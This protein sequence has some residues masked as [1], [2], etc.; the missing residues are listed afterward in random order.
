MIYKFSIQVWIVHF[1][2]HLMKQKNLIFVVDHKKYQFIIYAHTY[3]YKLQIALYVKQY[4]KKNLEK[5]YKLKTFPEKPNYDLYN[6]K[7]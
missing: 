5:N 6:I 1:N 7:Y 4:I 2:D 3:I